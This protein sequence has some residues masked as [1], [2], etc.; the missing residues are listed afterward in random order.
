[1]SNLC[2]CFRA[3]SFNEQICS[4]LESNYHSQEQFIFLWNKCCCLLA[5]AFYRSGASISSQKSFPHL[6]TSQRITNYPSPSLL[7]PFIFL[8]NFC[9]IVHI[10][11]VL[12]HS[13][14]VFF[15]ASD[16]QSLCCLSHDR[17]IVFSESSY[18][19]SAI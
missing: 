14:S 8:L 15:N 17:P 16:K 18:L 9:G 11:F 4:L 6:V 2:S 1:M 13:D 12:S 10:P 19:Q 5:P 7:F 3:L